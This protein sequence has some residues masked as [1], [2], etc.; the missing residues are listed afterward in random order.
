MPVDTFTAAEAAE[1][2]ESILVHEPD[3]LFITGAGCSADSGLPTY[4]G[5]AGL[6]EGNDKETGR[7]IEEIVSSDTWKDDPDLVWRHLKRIADACSGAEPN[8]AHKLIAALEQRLPR[9]WVLTQNVDGL[10]Q[11]AGSKNVITMHGDAFDMVCLASE[12]H[13]WR[14]E[15][16][17][18]FG[19][20]SPRCPTC[21]SLARP[22]VVLF[23]EMLPE[24]QV[25]KYRD[26]ITVKGF[27]VV[28]SVGTSHQFHYIDQ[29]VHN[30]NKQGGLSIEVNPT[31]SDLTWEF[32]Y[33]VRSGAAEA[34]KAIANKL[35]ITL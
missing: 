4:R 11:K 32:T 10:H 26:E 22:N 24:E 18:T 19:D 15:D 23:G 6:Y 27:D 25:Q 9:V 14:V 16:Y 5:V 3:I 7:P 1:L 17:S 13:G 35:G 34:A 28:V 31:G 21:G 20:V 29:P 12:D 8:A 33:R 2:F 30:V